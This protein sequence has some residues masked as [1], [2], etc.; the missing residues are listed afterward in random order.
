M[1]IH[2]NYQAAQ[3]QAQHLADLYHRPYV[4][5]IDTSGNPRVDSLATFDKSLPPAAETYY[6]AIAHT[7]EPWHAGAGNGEKHIFADGDGLRMRMESAGTTLYP[8]ASVNYGYEPREDAANMA[9]IVACVNGCEGIANPGAVQDLFKLAEAVV[10]AIPELP[11]AYVDQ[12]AV[13][14]AT[15]LADAR[16]A[17]AKTKSVV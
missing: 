13:P 7:P 9:R 4:A 6:P 10:R 11:P 15:L 16:A 5:F 17:I 8:L 14:L 12:A 1:G 3:L 2:K